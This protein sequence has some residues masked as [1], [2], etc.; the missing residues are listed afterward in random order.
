MIRGFADV[1]ALWTPLQLS[2][3]LKVP[4]QTAAGMY[5][6]GS[7]GSKHWSRLIEA[8]TARGEILTADMLIK[9]ADERRRSASD[10]SPPSSERIKQQSQ[11]ASSVIAS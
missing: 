4:Y 2:R 9:F 1:L 8:A 5:R 3:A 10:R 11:S 7:I 6:R